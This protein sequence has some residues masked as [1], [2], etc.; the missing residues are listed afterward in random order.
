MPEES[1]ESPRAGIM[2]IYEQP[3]VGTGQSDP[4]GDQQELLSPELP[5]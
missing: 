4:S 3:D 5:L 1:V 2:G